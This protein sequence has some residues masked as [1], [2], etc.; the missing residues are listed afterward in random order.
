MNLPSDPMPRRKARAALAV[1]VCV[2]T[3]ANAAAAAFVVSV[4]TRRPAALAPGERVPLGAGAAAS[5][6]R[7]VL[8]VL[9]E[10]S[11]EDLWA[12]AA[13]GMIE[14]SNAGRLSAVAVASRPG[15]AE[16]VAPEAG[17]QL[18]RWL[19]KR[20]PILPALLF[21][22]P[23]GGVAAAHMAPIAPGRLAESA[24]LFLRGRDATTSASALADPRTPFDPDALDGPR[25]IAM[26]AADP[27]V[28]SFLMRFRSRTVTR[29]ASLSYIEKRGYYWNVEF[30][31]APCGC[32]ASNA[33][34]AARVILRPLDGAVLSRDFLADAPVPGEPSGRPR[35]PSA[36]PPDSEA[37]L[38]GG[39]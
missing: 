26:A 13:A 12:L 6:G 7:R 9:G 1:A 22:E 23:D 31:A 16:T 8:L 2:L 33:A 24:A 10:D 30:R 21:L 15:S 19:T 18:K 4:A 3:A 28:A 25:A 20:L 34:P 17:P 5:D 14:Q 35:P 11:V 36:A 38:D 37:D 29:S 39:W 32:S 27:A